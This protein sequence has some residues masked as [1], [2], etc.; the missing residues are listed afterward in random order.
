MAIDLRKMT[1]VDLIAVA[2]NNHIEIP[3]KANKN[4]ILTIL[5]KKL[6]KMNLGEDEQPKKKKPKEE[7]PPIPA[8]GAKLTPE[9][10]LRIALEEDR[11]DIR[12]Y[13][14]MSGKYRTGLTADEMET[15]KKLVKKLGLTVK[16]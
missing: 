1:K 7:Q 8:K 5:E 16:E 11:E 9:Q 4:T 12:R 14:S 13:V 10:E 3:A 6:P 2:D 15:G